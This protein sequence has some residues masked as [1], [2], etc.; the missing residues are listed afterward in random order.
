M[1]STV[2]KRASRGCR[3]RLRDFEVRRARAG[4]ERRA[5][6]ETRT[7]HHARVG[8]GADARVGGTSGW[9]ERD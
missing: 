7:W 4:E 8:V 5:D 1:S 3:P 2:K 9:V 6:E